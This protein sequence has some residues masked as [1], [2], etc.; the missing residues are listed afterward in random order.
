MDLPSLGPQAGI[1]LGDIASG[2]LTTALLW[3]YI[4]SRTYWNCSWPMNRIDL[5]D[6]NLQ[7]FMNR[8]DALRLLAGA[9]PVA[10]LSQVLR[11]ASFGLQTLQ[12]F[13]GTHASLATYEIPQW[14]RDAKFGIWAH[15]G[16]Q[17]AAE[18]GDWYARNMYMQ[19]SEQYNYHVAHYGHPSKVGFKDIIPTWKAMAFDPGHLVGLYKKAGAK[20]FVSMGVHHD[21][22]DLW[23]SK[24]TRWSSV[25]MGPK[26]DVVAEFR[27]AAQKH[28][29][30]FGVSDHL[31]I[32]YKWFAVSHRSDSTGPLAGVLYDGTDLSNSDLY[33]SYSDP[34]LITAKLDWNEDGIP[35]SW[36]AHWS[37]RITDLIDQA[38]PDYLYSDGALPFGERGLQMAAHLY[39]L[40]AQRNGGRTQAVYLSKRPEDCAVGTCVLDHERG[41]LDEI[42]AN[43]W[44]A[45]T[46]V[47]NWH[48]KRGIEYKTPKFVIDMLVDV[49]SRN[50]NLMLN[51]PLPNNGMLDD[52]ELHILAEITDWMSVNGEAIYAT[53]PWK[54]SGI[55]PS[56]NKSANKETNFNEKNRK[57]LI[58]EDIR[59]T[60]KGDILYVLVMGIPEKKATVPLNAANT[61]T[62]RK[63]ANVELLGHSGNLQWT[64]DENALT[65]QMP[66]AAPSNFAVA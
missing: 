45:D 36:K 65:I 63:I 6:F 14:F 4:P 17:S 34:K 23:N 26:I 28:G 55:G 54:T 62:V 25:K 37:E 31:W 58:A 20:Y 66:E 46:C 9:I 29:L 15:W 47:G 30:Y 50:G 61:T 2:A 38:Q 57:D 19:G 43:P 48:Y 56:L 40:S 11:P 35:E 22:F 8:R 59:F 10:K 39:N 3:P 24:H 64:Q 13:Q 51:F 60:T 44:Q 41:V 1:W 53:R 16:P 18:D 49:V 21:N 32:S 5:E 27:K 12:S 33:H 52:Q 7:P 42:S